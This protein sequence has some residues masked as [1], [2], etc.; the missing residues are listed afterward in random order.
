MDLISLGDQIFLQK[1][2]ARTSL[3][4]EEYAYNLLSQRKIITLGIP[5]SLLNLL[6]E[7]LIL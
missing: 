5:E 6:M 7:C 4:V 2:L 1:P 3:L